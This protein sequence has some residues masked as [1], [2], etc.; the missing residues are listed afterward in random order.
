MT[1][2]SLLVLSHWCRRNWRNICPRLESPANIRGCAP[3]TRDACG[4]EVR[5]ENS[6][7]PGRVT[8]VL[9][10]TQIPSTLMQSTLSRLAKEKGHRVRAVGVL[11]AVVRIFNEIAMHAKAQASNRMAKAYRASHG[12]R[13]NPHTQPQVRVR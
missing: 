8:R 2:S 1:R 10:D 3:G 11:S 5:F 13:V 4:G 12:P 9:V 7:F 6:S